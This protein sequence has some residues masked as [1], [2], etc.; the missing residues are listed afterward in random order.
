MASSS[1]YSSLL[2]DNTHDKPLKLTISSVSSGTSHSCVLYKHRH[3]SSLNSNVKKNK[4][5]SV[6]CWGDN[7]SDQLNIP[8]NKVNNV[9]QVSAGHQHT[10]ITVVEYIQPNTDDLDKTLNNRIRIRNSINKKLDLLENIKYS[11]FAC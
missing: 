11:Q 5:Y 1:S 4:A 10:C 7:Q 2:N 3:T 6:K 8:S 9:S